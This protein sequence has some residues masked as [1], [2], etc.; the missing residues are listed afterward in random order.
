MGT[1]TQNTLVTLN[2]TAV[3]DSSLEEV[4]IYPCPDFAVTPRQ[5]D[6]GIPTPA[7]LTQLPHV[8]HLLGMDSDLIYAAARSVAQLR[9]SSVIDHS[10]L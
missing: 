10:V 2:N 1:K 8:F 4:V 6:S 5:S 9:G 7:S 3:A